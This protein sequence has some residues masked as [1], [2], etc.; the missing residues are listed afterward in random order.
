MT[1]NAGYKTFNTGDVLTA[2][3][4]QYNLQNQTVMYFATTT[5]RDAALTG[6]ILVEGMVSYVPSTGIKYYNGSAWV[7][8]GTASPLTTKG[9]VWGFS[10]TDARIPVGTNN[11]VLTADSTTA[12][13]VKWATPTAGSMTL[14]STTSLSGAST[15]ISS[16]SGSYTNLF[17][18]GQGITNAS[19]FISQVQANGSSTLS[20]VGYFDVGN[21]SGSRNSNGGLGGTTFA[22]PHNF[23]VTIN[24]YS[25]TSYNKTGSF[26]TFATSG[27]T[28]EFFGQYGYNSNSAITSLTIAASAGTFT[29][30]QVLIYGVN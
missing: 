15:T 4:V 9:D 29:G 28:P 19:S 3:Q 2:A 17:I 25:N 18:V 5:A 7:S 14:L 30:G 13:G 23:S 22:A 1:A 16:I 27:L 6:S 11:Q 26:V 12:L 21:I 20:N 8:P 24:N 10:T